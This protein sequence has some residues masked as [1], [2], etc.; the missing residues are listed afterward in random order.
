[1]SI[2]QKKLVIG[3]FGFGVVGEGLYKVLQ[4]TPT[5]NAEIKAICI[6]RPAK[7]RNA[8][9][10]LFTTER[11]ALLEDESINVIVELIDDAEAS[12]DIVSRALKKGKAVISANKKM[13]ASHLEELIRLQSEYRAPFLYE[14]ACC[15]SIPVIRNL[16][17]YYDNDLL[18]SVQ[19]IINGSTNYILTRVGEDK[20]DFDTALLQAQ[21]AGFAESDPRL[22]I[23]G[24]D[25]VNKLTILLTHAFGITAQ[26]EELLYTGIQNLHE[27]DARFAREKGY[28]I[29]LVAQAKKLEDGNVAAFVL[30]K[31]LE[32]ESQLFHV[33]NEFNGVVIE[34]G[35]ADNQFFYGKG[36]GGF[37]T[38]SAVLSDLSAL[39]YDYKYEYKKLAQGKSISVAKDFSLRVYISFPALFHVPQ[40][41]FDRIEAWGSND[42]RCYVIGEIAYSRLAGSTWW[43]KQGTSIIA[44]P[45]AIKEQVKDEELI[46]AHRSEAVLV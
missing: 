46:Y 6:K 36:A 37:P 18:Q 5:L 1:M 20:I 17:E 31:F 44:L 25:S 2:Q 13:I 10:N 40:E 15:A 23:E 3:L 26:P 9:A 45:E 35:L 33:K 8:P 30:P 4:K 39:R 24:I 27:E 22:D 7:S 29:R 38:A 41:A 11:E 43:K 19:G 12:Y 16:E 21:E 14:S 42:N 32:K 34:S 28:E